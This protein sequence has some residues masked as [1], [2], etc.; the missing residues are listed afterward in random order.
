MSPT[1]E[2]RRVLTLASD[3]TLFQFP[4][5]APD[6]RRLAV[7]GSGF[8]GGAIYVLEDVAR[9]GALDER[10]V[11][12]SAD[13]TPFYLYWSPD[14]QNLA[15]LANH[16]RNTIGLNV[17]PGDGT[18]DS[19]LLATGAPFYWDWSD[20]GRQLL[21]HS[22][23]SSD[24]TI[25]LIDLNGETQTANLAT[26][27]NFQAPD[28]GAGGRYWAFAED[29]ED[30]LSALVVVDTQSG[31]RRS[32]EQAG[33]MALGWSPTQPLVAF[34]NGAVDQ[35]PLW[36]PLRLLDVAAG[37]VRTLA[38]QTVLAFFWSPD[39][40]SIAFI[41]L[42]RDL[43]GE[44]VQANAPQK[45]RLSSRLDTVPAQQFGGG[46]LT[47]SVVDVATGR[48]LHL[49]DFVPTA[50]YLTQFLPFFDQ[51]A[52]SHRIWSPDGRALVLPVWEDNANVIMVVPANGGQ[53]YR[54]A[55]GEIAFW[56]HQ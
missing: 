14:S 42:G 45:V 30:G 28:I 44:S 47:L 55:E 35:H 26:P 49:L 23:R 7:V 27:G 29:I 5:W 15:F 22:G 3:D 32:F 41:T 10:E 54:L 39:G 53:P 16:S 25:A 31:E 20:N 43:G 50:T 13:N 17:V 21:V 46:F 4:A 48:G 1:G 56:S 12:S 19:R 51:Y 9:T 34:T 36:G 2:N 40:R 24:N 37:E 8:A 38:T 52:L 11:Y 18:A 6:G 33:S